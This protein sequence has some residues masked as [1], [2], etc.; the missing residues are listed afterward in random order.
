MKKVLA[1]CL[2]LA[3]A[4]SLFAFPV[5]ADTQEIVVYLNGER[6]EFDVSPQIIDNRTMVPMRAIFEALGAVVYWSKEY[7]HVFTH[8]RFGAQM[9][10][11]QEFSQSF[12]MHLRPGIYTATIFRGIDPPGGVR[13]E[14]EFDVPPQIINNR[15]LVPLRAV[16]EVFGAS[17]EWNAEARV[18]TIELA[19]ETPERKLDISYLLGVW[20]INDGGMMQ[21]FGVTLYFRADGTGEFRNIINIFIEEPPFEIHSE[22]FEWSAENGQ[23]TWGSE[24]LGFVTYD[25]HL[26]YDTLHIRFPSP[27]DGHDGMFRRLGRV[28]SDSFFKTYVP[29]LFYGFDFA[30]K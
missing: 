3:L 7:Q 29:E 21:H 14:I 20:M 19:D 11:E 1:I 9:P 10:T 24:T 17:V 22:P 26:Y 4:T 25:F 15:M 18:V 30:A 6:V 13:E 27:E 12:S 23:L 16:S 8:T 28:S 5:V 2:V